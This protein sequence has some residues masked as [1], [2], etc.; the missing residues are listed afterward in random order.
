MGMR[1]WARRPRPYVGVWRGGG[2][3]RG[4][5]APT[6][7]CG[8]EADTGAATAPLQ[9]GYRMPGY[10]PDRHHRRS[11]RLKGYDYSQSGAYFVTICAHDGK[12]LFGQVVDGDMVLSDWGKIVVEYWQGIPEHFPNVEVDAFVAMPNHVHG[13]IMLNPA[14]VGAGSPR[15]DSPMDAAA[16]G[17]VTAPLHPA[18]TNVGVERPHPGP[19]TGAATAPLRRPT[20]GQIVAYFKYQST[21]QINLQRGTP[22]IPIWQ[23]NYYEHIVRS[24]RALDAIREYIN[25]NPLRWELDRYNPQAIGRDP[26]A[27]SLWNLLQEGPT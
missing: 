5:R 11:I 16:T 13:I 12:L 23:R 24:E 20:P 27:A 21:K 4:D 14:H 7:G 18:T 19:S 8:V 1:K 22:G 15:P 3:G 6:S 10:D 25:D 26:R 17:A 2:N 9:G